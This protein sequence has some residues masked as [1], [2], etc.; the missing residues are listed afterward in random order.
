MV[1][2]VDHTP[3]ARR[4]A[5]HCPEGRHY[6]S[7]SYSTL[8]RATRFAPR[9]EP[10]VETGELARR[11]AG[12]L[13]F[14]GDTAVHFR[15]HCPEKSANFLR[16]A[17]GHEL[18]PAVAKVLHKPGHG[19]PGRDDPNRVAETDALNPPTDPPLCTPLDPIAAIS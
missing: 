9:L 6:L 10:D 7:N 16:R 13:L 5:P 3:P 15:V 17:F 11:L 1:V 18:H 19:E 8:A 14:L 2:L 12:I 4:A